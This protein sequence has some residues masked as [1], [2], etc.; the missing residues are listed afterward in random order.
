MGTKRILE[1]G[2]GSDLWRN[3]LSQIPSVFG[4]LVYLS[5]LRNPNSARYSH[6]GLAL[7]FGEEEANRALRKSHARAFHDWLSFNLERQ[8]SD[9]DLY[10]SALFEDRKTVLEA[11]ISLT[12]YRNLIPNSAKTMERRLYLADFNAILE[13]LKNEYAAEDPDRGA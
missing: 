3:T 12:P 10:L 11:W 6:H 9:L 1:R 4:R 2:A 8:K 5:A 13:L 7:M